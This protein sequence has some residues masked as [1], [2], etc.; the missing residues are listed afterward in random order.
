MLVKT[1]L[2]FMGIPLLKFSF[3]YIGLSG[4]IQHGDHPR[5]RLGTM[6]SIDLEALG[7]SHERLDVPVK[8]DLT[9]RDNDA[10]EA[11]QAAIEAFLSNTDSLS[12][13]F[14]LFLGGLEFGSSKLKSFK[15]LSKLEVDLLKFGSITSSPHDIPLKIVDVSG[16]VQ[17]DLS[18]VMEVKAKMTAL[19][20]TLNAQLGYA[21]F[22]VWIDSVEIGNFQVLG[23][24]NIFFIKPRFFINVPSFIIP[25]LFWSQDSTLLQ[26][27]HFSFTES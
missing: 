10:L 8:L 15:L 12:S 22:N 6:S 14:S 7:G 24:A 5:L 25:S 17:E 21:A 13:Q 19:P 23:E 26:M 16:K 20:F 2:D 4:F 9:N 11:V 27:E 1:N 18:M 3:G